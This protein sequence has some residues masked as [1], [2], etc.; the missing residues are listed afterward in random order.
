MYIL[1]INLSFGE[2][3]QSCP[4]CLKHSLKFMAIIFIKYQFLVFIFNKFK[5]LFSFNLKHNINLIYIYIYIY[6]KNLKKD[7]LLY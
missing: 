3:L 5:L 7:S 6:I 1:T 2:N 4:V